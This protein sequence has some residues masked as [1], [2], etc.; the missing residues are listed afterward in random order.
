[1]MAAENEAGQNAVAQPAAAESANPQ[2]E[3]DINPWSVEGAQGENGEIIP[4]DYDAI[5]RYVLA[6]WLYSRPTFSPC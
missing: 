1:M 5:C 4:I 3:Q 2:R 6:F